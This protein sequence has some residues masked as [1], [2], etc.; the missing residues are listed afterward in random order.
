M[1][2]TEENAEISEAQKERDTTGDRLRRKCAEERDHL[3]RESNNRKR[4]A[5]AETRLLICAACGGMCLDAK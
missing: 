5:V 4:K 1:S 2:F 3:T